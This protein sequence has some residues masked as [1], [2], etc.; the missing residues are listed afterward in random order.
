MDSRYKPRLGNLS[1][2]VCQAVVRCVVQFL[3][4]VDMLVLCR[5]GI[6]SRVTCLNRRN[7]TAT[8]YEL[9]V[10]TKPRI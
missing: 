5:K 1:K 10:V 2:P 8:A 3:S 7:A 6:S 4:V 9:D